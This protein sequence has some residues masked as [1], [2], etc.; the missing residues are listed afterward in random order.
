MNDF[1]QT[2]LTEEETEALIAKATEQVAKRRL[3]APAIMFLEMHKPLSNV[4]A[5]AAVVFAPF[6][7]PLFGFDTVNDFS[8]FLTKRENVERLI[9]SIERSAMGPAEEK[10]A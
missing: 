10:P 9:Q 3:H 2:E 1:W 6:L 7:V 4:A 8:R 5:N